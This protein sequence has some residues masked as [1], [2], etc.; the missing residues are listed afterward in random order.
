[1]REIGVQAANGTLSTSDNQALDAEFQQLVK[2]IDRIAQNTTWAG[3]KLLDG[4]KADGTGPNDTFNDSSTFSFQAGVGNNSGNDVFDV[5]IKDASAFDLGV[6]AYT[7]TGATSSTTNLN[8]TEGPDPVTDDANYV[9]TNDVNLLSQSSAQTAIGLVDTA[10]ATV[11]SERANLGAVSNRM[12]STMANLDQIRV[13]LTASQGRIADA[14]FAAET[15]N[16]AKGQILQQA[17]T[18]MLAQANA[19]KQQVLTLIR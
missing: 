1:M 9:T 14:D 17:A 16:L 6:R 15:A 8:Q 5:T 10:I 11:S 4:N 19:S 2:E 18:A 12:A 13:N 7:A 3:E